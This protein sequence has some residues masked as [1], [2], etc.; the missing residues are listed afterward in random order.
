M[1][2]AEK[3]IQ[4][5]RDYA[6]DNPWNDVIY[7]LGVDE[8][9]SEKLSGWDSSEAVIFEDGS[10]MEWLQPEAEWEVRDMDEWHFMEDDDE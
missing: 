2:R 7:P 1:T 6:G 5:L 9:L 10:G 8:D 3:A 4:M